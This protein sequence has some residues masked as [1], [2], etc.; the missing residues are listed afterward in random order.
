MAQF[1]TT[2]CMKCRKRQEKT[3]AVGNASTWFGF[4]TSAICARKQQYR[5]PRFCPEYIQFPKLAD[6][7]LPRARYFFKNVAK[8]I[9]AGAHKPTNRLKSLVLLSSKSEKNIKQTET[10]IDIMPRKQQ[11]VLKNIFG[12]CSVNSLAKLGRGE[13]L[14]F[15]F[16]KLYN[17]IPTIGPTIPIINAAKTKTSKLGDMH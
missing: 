12:L 4:E 7:Y 16:K 1:I 9:R 14:I 5:A 3:A 15:L 10:A 6:Y 2:L 13:L 11:D 8:L 17:K